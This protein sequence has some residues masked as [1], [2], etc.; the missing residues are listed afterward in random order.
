MAVS[1]AVAG[2]TPQS[3]D[4]KFFTEY[5]QESLYASE[6]GTSQNSIIQVKEDLTKKRGDSVT[7]ALANALSGA[8][9]TG[10]ETLVG[11]EEAMLT[12]SFKLTVTQRRNAVV[13]S[14]YD[15]QLSAI[16]L[17]EAGREVLM[18]WA[19]QNTIAQVE[20]ALIS[21]NGTAYASAD[22]TARNV[23]LVDN[24]D[25]VLFGAAKSNNAA[26]VH[27]DAI[28][29]VDASADTL[30]ASAVSLMKRIAL[31]AS[32]PV[33]PVRSASS[34]RRYFVMYANALSFRDLKSDSTITAAQR[35]VSLKMQNEKLFDGGDI[36]WDG[37]IIKESDTLGSAESGTG[38]SSIDVGAV[39]LCGAQA[40]GYGIAKRWNTVTD[41]T[42]Y[43]DKQ[44]V[45]VREFGGIAKLT[46]GSNASADTGDLKDH[47]IVTGW[48]AAVADS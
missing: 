42:D 40:I 10:S 27:A 29:A 20:A 17:R 11:S 8:G 21:I 47:G 13:V 12:R 31:S 44:G 39:L 33:R 14:D 5:F 25:R 19:Q 35:E 41:D 2:L 16:P 37:V 23:W 28:T 22:A 26:N 15:E 48:F 36:Y 3:W 30:T 6:F 24:S 32:P 18:D 38:A 4:D 43:K 46:F 45:A 34:G 9:K 7:F 1:A